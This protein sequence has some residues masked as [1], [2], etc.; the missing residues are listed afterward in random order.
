MVRD[1]VTS[2]RAKAEACFA[3][4]RSTE[5][6]GE[7]ESAIAR[8]TAICAKHNLTLDGFDIPGRVKTIRRLEFSGTTVENLREAMNQM[9]AQM[10]RDG[11]YRDDG[12]FVVFTFS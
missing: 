6:A 5:F 10:Q 3:L 8:G 4:A 7:R 1:M 12:D 11:S 9:R 2:P